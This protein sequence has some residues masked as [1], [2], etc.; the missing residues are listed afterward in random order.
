MAPSV[1]RTSPRRTPAALLDAL[2]LLL[3][4]A[5]AGCGEPDRGLCD[6][7]RAALAPHPFRAESRGAGTAVW[8]AV[9]YEGTAARVIR[10]FKD[11]GR[12][13]AARP[14][15]AALRQSLAAAVGALDAR[16]REVAAV[17]STAAAGRARGYDPVRMLVRHAGFASADVLRAGARAD[18]AALGREARRA[19]SEG[20]FTARRP[21]AGRR[22]VLVDDIVTTGSTLADAARAI[23]AAGG[24]V[25]AISVLARTRLRI[26]RVDADA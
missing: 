26:G 6:G 3:P 11:E 14:L 17:P 15:G 20:S 2:A 12:T 18:Q 8:A 24:S 22:F 23:R 5:C 10:A 21:L 1:P 4:V 7:C 25:D 9:E 13:D 19:N 16:P